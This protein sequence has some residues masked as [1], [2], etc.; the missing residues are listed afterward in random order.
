M[1]RGRMAWVAE[2]ERSWVMQLATGGS[3]RLEV[4]RSDVAGAAATWRVLASFG[5]SPSRITDV[6]GSK[7]AAQ[8]CALLLAMRR[9]PALRG[10]L[11]EQIDLVPRA[12]WWKIVPLDDASAE[13]RAIVSDRVSETEE[14][15]ERSG[16][17]AGAGWYLY[18]YGPGSA[19]AF[20]QLPP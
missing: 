18:V 10:A 1:Q 15:A 7:E 6:F 20:G 5:G 8:G 11:H 16:R 9:L 3:D 17:A 19:L 14:S 12:W 2:G 4:R 13:P